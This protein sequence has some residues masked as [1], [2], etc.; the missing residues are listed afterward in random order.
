MQH[1]TVTNLF[2]AV[3]LALL[4]STYK[5]IEVGGARS[6]MIKNSMTNQYNWVLESHNIVKTSKFNRL[7]WVVDGINKYVTVLYKSMEVGRVN[8]DVCNTLIE[9][10]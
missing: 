7:N 5:S 3:C 8:L 6:Q 2:S 4:S 10:D 1:S 9:I